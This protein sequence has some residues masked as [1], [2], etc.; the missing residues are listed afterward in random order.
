ML[1]RTPDVGSADGMGKPH[2]SVLM[3]NL[4]CRRPSPPT[5]PFVADVLLYDLLVV[6][7]PSDD[8]EA[9]RWT[10]RHRQPDLQADLIEILGAHAVPVPWSLQLHD[11]WAARYD[12]EAKSEPGDAAVVEDMAHAVA[13]DAN[14]VISARESSASAQP[15]RAEPGGSR[16][17]RAQGGQSG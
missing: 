3:G 12:A 10:G 7:V 8:A 2:D 4:L 6:P 14:N 5:H 15:T 1:V 13:F 11:A 16:S 17:Q 9:A